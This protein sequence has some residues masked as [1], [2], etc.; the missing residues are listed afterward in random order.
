MSDSFATSW[1]VACQVPLW[2][3][4]GKNT[5]VSAI[6]F[7]RGIFLTHASNPCLLHWQ[8]NSLLLS[9]LGR[10]S[11]VVLV[12]KN[13]PVNAGDIKDVGSI[14]GWG[15]SPGEV[16]GN[17]LRYSCLENSMDRGAW[18]ATFHGI[19]KDRTWLTEHEPLAKH[20]LFFAYTNAHIHVELFLVL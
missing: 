18:Q 9:H 8:G 15:R 17:P 20:P 1:T 14:P 11:Q 19:A 16:N 10:A 7:S 2:D 12:I 6:Y 3:F 4:A 5:G 13:L